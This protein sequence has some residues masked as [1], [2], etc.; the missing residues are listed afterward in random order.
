MLDSKTCVSLLVDVAG[1]LLPSIRTYADAE[2]LATIESAIAFSQS[3]LTNPNESQGYAEIE[4][5]ATEL[6][7]RAE[8]YSQGITIGEEDHPLAKLTHE[9]Q[10]NVRD[11]SDIAAG[12]VRNTAATDLASANQECFDRLS[13]ARAMVD[14]SG[15]PILASVV[16]GLIAVACR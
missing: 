12:A 3:W 11:V 2:S 8:L 16:E 5:R 1:A 13:W 15:D 9:Q 7:G 6:T 4:R 10:E 14:R